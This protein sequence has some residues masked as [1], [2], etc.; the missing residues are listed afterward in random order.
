MTST[1]PTSDQHP[2]LGGGR[3]LQYLHENEAYANGTDVM[4]PDFKIIPDIYGRP[5]S[6]YGG[7]LNN[8]IFA[9]WNDFSTDSDTGD[10]SVR[11]LWN[12]NTKILTIGWYNLKSYN[13]E[14]NNAEANF[15]VQLNFNDDSFRIVRRFWK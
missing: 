12:S 3:P 1:N 10:W 15:E 9:L 4:R 8:T 5:S 6:S 11:Q 7:N 2:Y 13:G 14:D